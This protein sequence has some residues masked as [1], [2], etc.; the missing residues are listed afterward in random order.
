[1]KNYSPKKPNLSGRVDFGMPQIKNICNGRTS[2][3]GIAKSQN[4]NLNLFYI[5]QTPPL[6]TKNSS[7]VKMTK[8]P[9]FFVSTPQKTKSIV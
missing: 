5:P 7:P 6:S 2:E 4:L 9:D 1:M 8:V 3:I